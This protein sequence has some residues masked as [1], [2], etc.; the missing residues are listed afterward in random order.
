MLVFVWWISLISLIWVNS[1]NLFIWYVCSYKLHERRRRRYC[2]FRYCGGLLCTH[3]LCAWRV[4][5]LKYRNLHNY[6]FWFSFQFKS[7]DK[8]NK[9]SKC[10]NRNHHF[11]RVFNVVKPFQWLKVCCAVVLDFTFQ[12]MFIGWRWNVDGVR[13]RAREGR[14]PPSSNSFYAGFTASTQFWVFMTLQEL[15]GPFRKM[16][17]SHRVLLEEKL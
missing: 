11:N 13:M 16:L 17:G 9:I 10:T 6:S 7:F 12:R 5:N 4:C 15:C 3:T 8:S 14:E 1:T 2:K